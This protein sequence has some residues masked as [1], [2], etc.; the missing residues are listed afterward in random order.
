M[1]CNQWR[2]AVN[3][4]PIFDDYTHLSTWIPS[5]V[6][7][8]AEKRP[9]YCWDKPVGQQQRWFIC[10]QSSQRLVNLLHY[11]SKLNSLIGQTLF[12]SVLFVKW[13]FSI[14]I[15]GALE[16]KS[17][18]NWRKELLS[19]TNSKKG[20]FCVPEIK[21]GRFGCFVIN[22]TCNMSFFLQIQPHHVRSWTRL[23]MRSL[24]KKWN[25]TCLKVK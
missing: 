24:K 4:E 2:M 21:N 13:A 14:P 11:Y 25:L 15:E 19:A 3:N 6:T 20:L 8:N 1:W 12:D 5:Q 16:Q 22:K 10:Q 9:V 23:K 17:K 7:T 18:P